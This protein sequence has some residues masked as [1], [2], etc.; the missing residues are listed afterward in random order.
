VKLVLTLAFVLSVSL[1]PLGAWPIY[2]LLFALALSASVVAEL[3]PTF[4]LRRAFVALPFVLAALPLLVTVKGVPLLSIPLGPWSLT[5]TGLGL[6]RFLSIAVKSWL[7][8]QIAIL[9]TATTPLTD[10]LV[11]MRALHLPRLLIAVLGLMWRYLAVLIDEAMRMVR[12]REARSGSWGDRSG[13]SLTWRARVTGGMAGSLFVRGYERSERIYNAMLARG[14]D[15]SIR[16]FPLNPLS[17]GERL[18][19]ISALVVLLVL[20]LLG[21]SAW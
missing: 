11:A 14:Y 8:V 21:Y 1:S 5:V 16:S 7:S 3:R 18:I 20:L 19:L 4:V 17:S 6:E 9:L 12:A 13:G 10:L 2:V 15:G